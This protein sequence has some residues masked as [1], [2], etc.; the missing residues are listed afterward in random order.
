MQFY[1]ENKNRPLNFHGTDER[2]L[3]EAIKRSLMESGAESEQPMLAASEAFNYGTMGGGSGGGEFFDP[4]MD[5]ELAEALKMS[6]E[7][8]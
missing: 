3:E 2:D 1:E 7:M 4:S 5:P 8:N 6:L